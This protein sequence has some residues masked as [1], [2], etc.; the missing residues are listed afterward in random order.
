MIK[1]APGKRN[2]KV[3]KAR[4]EKDL[5]KPWIVWCSDECA[6]VIV[7]EKQEKI[8]KKLQLQY[9]A[10]A[11]EEK[12]KW[13]GEK[14]MMIENTMKRGDWLKRLETIINNIAR[15]IDFGTACISCGGF[16]KP[17]AGHYHSV[18]SDATIR[19]NLHNEHLQDYRCNVELGSNTIGYDEGL[20]RVYGREYWEYVK[21][22]LKNVYHKPLNLS[23]PEIKIYID[24]A[25]II[26]KRLEKDQVERSPEE[27]IEL[28]DLINSEI[29]IY[30]ETFLCLK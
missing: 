12:K 25:R 18:A 13:A 4:F 26:L 24:Q 22:G 29:G 17:Q 16:G 30:K 9:K 10:R 28:R 21:F 8:N 2:C 19:F 1:P 7:K 14:K 5:S 3:C 27:R 11:S 15:L 6:L 20:I 23:I